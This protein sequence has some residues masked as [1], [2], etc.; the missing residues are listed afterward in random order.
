M[1]E[2]DE[3]ISLLHNEPRNNGKLFLFPM[4]DTVHQARGMCSYCELYI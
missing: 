4:V 1:S 3:A 2:A